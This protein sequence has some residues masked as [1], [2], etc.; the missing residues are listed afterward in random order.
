MFSK[1]G[2]DTQIKMY[3]QTIEQVKKFKFLGVCSDVKLSWKEHIQRIETKCK[4]I[5]NVMRYLRALEW[6]ASGTAM[7]KYLYKTD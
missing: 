6:G 5:L 1:R 2:I 4:I 3:G 7:K